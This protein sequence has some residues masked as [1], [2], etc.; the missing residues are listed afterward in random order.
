V[1]PTSVG[2]KKPRF[3]VSPADKMSAA[4]Q[5]TA[6]I[7]IQLKLDSRHNPDCSLKP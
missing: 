6:I 4:L 2:R 3:R 7:L 5:V 1:L